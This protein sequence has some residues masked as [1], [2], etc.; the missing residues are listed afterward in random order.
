MIFVIRSYLK[1]ADSA[2]FKLFFGYGLISL[3]FAAFLILWLLDGLL[4]HVRLSL[5]HLGRLRHL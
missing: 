3:S 2:F 5:R 4:T 1:N